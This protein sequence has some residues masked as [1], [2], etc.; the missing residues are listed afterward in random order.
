MFRLPVDARMPP[1]ELA[2]HQAE[3]LMEFA[4]NEAFEHV[5]ALEGKYL[6]GVEGAEAPLLAFREAARYLVA[7]KNASTTH[8][9]VEHLARAEAV[10][11]TAASQLLSN[12]QS[13]LA[14]ELPKALEIWKQLT[15]ARLK[16]GRER[17][18]HELPNPFRAGQ[19]LRPDQ[20][21]SVFRGRE[22]IVRQID[23]ILADGNQGGSIALLGPRRCGKTSLLQMLPALLPDCLCIF[24]DLQ[25]N[26][27]DSTQSF[28]E[29]ICRQ[30]REQARRDRRIDLPGLANGATFS[31]AMEWFQELDAIPGNFRILLCVDEFERLEDLF[32]GNRQDLLRLMGLF[33]ATIQHRRKLRFLVSGVAPFDE[34][35]QIWNDH[36]INVRQ[37]WVGH[38]EREA[39]IDLLMRPLA[40]FPVGV[41]PEEVANL[42]YERT[43][44]QPYLLQLYGTL[45]IAHLNAQSRR[46][47]IPEDIATVE[48][49]VTSQGAYYFRHSYEA[50]PVE[51]REALERLACGK[52]PTMTRPTRQWLA[53]RGW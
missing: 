13:P 7:A 34:L 12:R 11:M 8:N 39:A 47:A 16:A 15:R 43:G 23:S 53:R 26:P 27:V 9:A 3:E 32:P 19:P 17:L 28:F 2:R 29:A 22:E 24:F 20:G 18:A 44:G 49:D 25:D 10:L 4:G 46:R 33:R 41:V 30:A 50:V 37:I 51:A 52:S 5:V 1:A 36:F 14:A 48:E 40:D 45:L 35:G 21:R 31:S 38:L 42:V 6:P